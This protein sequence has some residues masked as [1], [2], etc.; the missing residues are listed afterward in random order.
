MKKITL[1]LPLFF[2]LKFQLLFLGY[3]NF[4]DRHVKTI[5]ARVINQ[6]KK[7]N[8]YVLKLKNREVT[9]YTVSREDLKNLLNERVEVKI[10]TKNISF[11][12][13]LTKFY[14][15]SFYLKLL[16]LNYFEAF[17]EKQHKKSEIS[18]L[19][20]ALFLGESMDYK[21]RIKLSTLGIS[22]LFALSGLHLGFISAILYFLFLPF[23]N[24]FHKKR[25]Y[26][27]RF[28]DL[29][30]VILGVELLYL[31]FTNFPPSLIRA[32]VMEVLLFV[33]AYFLA[34]VLSFKV[35]VFTVMFA[36]LIFTFSVFSLG[37]LLS[38]LGVYYIYLFLNYYK[39][40]WKNSLILSVYMFMVMF[41][42]SHFFFGQ[43]NNYQLLSPFVNIVFPFFYVAEVFLHFMGYGGVL[44][45]VIQKYLNL[46]E[47][48]YY[49]KISFLFLAGFAFISLLALKKK[50][51]FYGINLLALFV[52]AGSIRI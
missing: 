2:I 39:I 6:Y 51:A 49:V 30:M 5:E 23:Y 27:N 41:V 28:V 13:Y 40:T 9:F 47:N 8:Y 15:T 26:R 16:P 11:L 46:G 50:W 31:W 48:F 3:I 43:F 12:G 38:I 14:A 44:D 42:W 22:H 19:F 18:N 33:F 21:T 10:F 36:V 37:F 34:D 7:K 35:L 45:G 17:I 25:P 24:F 29:G 32:Y 4:I 1:F 20:R 52:I